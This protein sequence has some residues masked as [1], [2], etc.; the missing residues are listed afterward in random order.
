MTTELITGFAGK[1]HIGSD[2]MGAWNAGTIGPDTYVLETGDQL[3]F[4]LT[5]NNNGTLGTGDCSVDGRH[6]RVT[7]AEELTI[8]SGTQGQKRNDLVVFHYEKDASTGV[9]TAVPKIIKGT[10]AT[11]GT[12]PEIEEA[13]ILSGSASKDTPLWRLPIDGLTVGEPVP[14]F[15]TLPPLA[16]VWDSVTPSYPFTNIA[17]GGTQYGTAYFWANASGCHLAVR[18]NSIS[19]G[20]YDH[21]VVGQLPD[22]R[23]YPPTL[24]ESVAA[25]NDFEAGARRSIQISKTGAITWNNLGGTQTMKAA[26][27]FI[28]W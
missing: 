23:Y 5:D 6:I 18:W 21:G 7:A 3:K 8:E 27:A 19:S 17:T 1:P 4:T 25:G 14:L 11:T 15:K 10:P 28:S 16:S 12:D 26:Y 22:A 24:L 13:S 2:D 20:S 9:E